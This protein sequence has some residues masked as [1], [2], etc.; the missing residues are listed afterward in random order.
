MAGL[1]T[2]FLVYVGLWVIAFSE[3]NVRW[4]ATHYATPVEYRGN[5]GP[6]GRHRVL[7]TLSGYASGLT[8]CGVLPL[9]ALG[10]FVERTR[11]AKFVAWLAAVMLLVDCAHFPLF[12]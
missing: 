2:V 3:D 10:A 7:G 6:W 4:L 11:R 5:G 9:A 12:D 1:P 8:I